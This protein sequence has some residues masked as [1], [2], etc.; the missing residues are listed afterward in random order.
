MSDVLGDLEQIIQE[1]LSAAPTDSYVASLHAAGL[2]KILEKVGEESFEV[3]LAARD[4]ETS[5]NK[6]TVVEET[7][8]LLFHTLVMLAHLGLSHKDVLDV[9]AQRQGLSGIAEKASRGK[10]QA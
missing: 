8:D 1:R 5:E 7:A 3:V 10:N 4:C 6:T 2:N 9:L